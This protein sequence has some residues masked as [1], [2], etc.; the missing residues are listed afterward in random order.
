MKM[1]KH[2]VEEVELETERFM[3]QGDVGEPDTDCKKRKAA[4]VL[5]KL[6]V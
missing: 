4:L 1:G 5:K 6:V 3:Q 2:L